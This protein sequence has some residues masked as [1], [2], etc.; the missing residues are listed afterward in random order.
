MTSKDQIPV[1][2]PPLLHILILLNRTSRTITFSISSD[3]S[4]DLAL[5]R[6][7]IS[8]FTTFCPPVDFVM[9]VPRDLRSLLL[10]TM[11]C[12]MIVMNQP[13]FSFI[14]LLG[15]TELQFL[16]QAISL[17]EAPKYQF[18]VFSFFKHF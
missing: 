17:V 8:L 6:P 9:C 10:S 13:N 3:H 4:I 15:Q 14:L 12:L 5:S 16:K 1:W 7:G 18:C 2:G 11:R